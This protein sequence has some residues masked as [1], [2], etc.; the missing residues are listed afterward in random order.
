MPTKKKIKIKTS[1]EYVPDDPRFPGRAIGR[2]KRNV[3]KL[4]REAGTAEITIEL[5][6]SREKRTVAR[7][8]ATIYEGAEPTYHPL[9]ATLDGLEVWYDKRVSQ[10]RWEALRRTVES[11]DVLVVDLLKSSGKT[12]GSLSLRGRFLNGAALK[13]TDERLGERVLAC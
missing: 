2:L 5:A 3:R 9:R 13:F 7:A 6:T 1:H 10:G 12:S 8:G 11:G 4:K